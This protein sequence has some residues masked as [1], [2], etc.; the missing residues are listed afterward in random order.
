[1]SDNMTSKPNG[2]S[3]PSDTGATNVGKDE[4]QWE[5]DLL[6]RL[7]FAS[8]NEQRRTRRWSIFFKTLAFVYV[9]TILFAYRPESWQSVGAKAGKHTALVEVSGIIAAGGE[10]SADNIITGLRAAFE[11]SKTSG[12]IMR[13]NS[14]GGSPVQAGYINDEMRRLRAEYPDTPLYAVVADICASGGYYI[15][16]AADEIYADKASIIGSIGVRMDSFGFVD[17]MEKLGVERRLM[18]AGEHKGFLD[19]FLPSNPEDVAHVKTLLDGIHEQFIATVRQGR[20]ERLKPDERMFSGLVWTGEQG[21]EL[22]LVDGLGSAS[23]VAREL[24]GEEEIV[25]Y[26]PKP[27]LFEKFAGGM[28]TAMANALMKVTGGISLR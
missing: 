23:Y 6:N 9:F 18:T 1:M 26:T 25:D 14:P 13:I 21:V 11:D 24:I 27:D 3:E 5:R 22:G 16:A 4:T 28:G 2:P 8:V 17:A 19:P 20:G 15:A 7:A 12:V 10:A